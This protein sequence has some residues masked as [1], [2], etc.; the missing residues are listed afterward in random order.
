MPEGI[1]NFAAKNLPNVDALFEAYHCYVSE[2]TD[3]YNSSFYDAWLFA[4]STKGA[5]AERFSGWNN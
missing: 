4:D 1:L 3:D 5:T 2:K